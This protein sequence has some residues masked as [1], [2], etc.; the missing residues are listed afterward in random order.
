MSNS[1][2]NDT[3]KVVLLG[4]GSDKS[5]LFH[6]FVANKFQKAH[7]KTI[8]MEPSSRYETIDGRKVSFSIWDITHLD[9]FKPMRGM[10]YRNTLGAMVVFDVTQPDT[11]LN[12]DKWINELKIESPDVHLILIGMLNTDE[13]NRKVTVEQAQTKAEELGALKYIETSI[14]SGEHIEEAFTLLGKRILEDQ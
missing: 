1:S 13:S 6:K 7:L 11:F 2:D 3:F 12:V 8:G 10:F 4:D 9:R 5:E 14:Q